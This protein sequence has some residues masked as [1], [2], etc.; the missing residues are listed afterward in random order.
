MT[1][2]PGARPGS[3]PGGRAPIRPRTRCRPLTHPFLRFSEQ[4]SFTVFASVD[5]ASLSVTSPLIAFDGVRVCDGSSRSEVCLSVT[6]LLASP[7]AVSTS[8]YWGG[9]EANIPA[10]PAT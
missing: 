3:A 8:Y 4:L 2:T 5:R 1:L 9:F 10:Q 6:A 7:G